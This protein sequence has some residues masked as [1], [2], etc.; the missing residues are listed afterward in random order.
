MHLFPVYRWTKLVPIFRHYPHLPC[1][2]SKWYCEDRDQVGQMDW[3]AS[4]WNDFQLVPNSSVIRRSRQSSKLLC[5][6]DCGTEIL[7]LEICRLYPDCN[8][9]LF[10]MVIFD[11]PANGIIRVT[12][13]GL[14]E[15]LKIKFLE[16]W[17]HRR[18]KETPAASWCPL[19][20]TLNFSKGSPLSRLFRFNKFVEA[21]DHGT[22]WVSAAK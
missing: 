18:H 14:S 11:R 13:H 19:T 12:D 4:Y 20:L 2:N 17:K 7:S 10:Q 21:T 16:N 15:F 3:E 9:V 8:A 22:Y 5:A 6:I 1:R